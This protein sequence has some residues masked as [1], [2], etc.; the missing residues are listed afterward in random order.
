VIQIFNVVTFGIEIYETYIMLEGMAAFHNN[1]MQVQLYGE[2]LWAIAGWTGTTVVI[3]FDALMVRRAIKLAMCVVWTMNTLRQM[4]SI[5]FIYSTRAYMVPMNFCIYFECWSAEVVRLQIACTVLVYLI[6]YAVSLL[7]F[8]ESMII[9]KSPV[10]Y[11]CTD[12]V[13]R[14]RVA[15]QPNQSDLDD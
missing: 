8:P 13:R 10:S 5:V 4:Y 9:L 2:W 15:P 3:C 11:K 7:L 14:Q 12:K 6:K 1:T